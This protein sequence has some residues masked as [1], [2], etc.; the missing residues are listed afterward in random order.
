MAKTEFQKTHKVTYGVLATSL[1]STTVTGTYWSMK[2]AHHAAVIF[3]IG[4]IAAAVTISIMQGKAAGAT[5]ATI[6]GKS[7]AL[8]TGDANSVQILEVEASEL[9][10]ANGYETIAARAVAGGAANCDISATVIRWPLRIVPASL[11][12]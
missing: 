5:P 9:N 1:A 3:T 12:T 4:A 7:T 10:V 8:G 11:I 2:E 6:A